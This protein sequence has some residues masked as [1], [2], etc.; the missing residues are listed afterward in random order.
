MYVLPVTVADVPLHVLV[1]SAMRTNNRRIVQLKSPVVVKND[2]SEPME[3]LLCESGG[4]DLFAADHPEH[5]D[6]PELKRITE[7][8]G[9]G[10]RLMEG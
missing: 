4:V 3:L 8:R 9:V 1:K 10:G 6:F 7:V 2:T 5:P